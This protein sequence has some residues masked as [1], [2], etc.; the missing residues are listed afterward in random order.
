ME[1]LQKIELSSNC[2][3]GTNSSYG[4]FLL[5]LQNMFFVLSA[6]VILLQVYFMYV[7]YQCYIILETRHQT[8]VVYPHLCLAYQKY[9]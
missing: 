3:N 9:L 8:C 2:R 4:T 7:M 6:H 1:K 5:H